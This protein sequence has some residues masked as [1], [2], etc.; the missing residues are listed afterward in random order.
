MQENRDKGAG[1]AYNKKDE[2]LK[3]CRF[4]QKKGKKGRRKPEAASRSEDL[5]D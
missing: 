1:K 3:T 5:P 4:H 2:A